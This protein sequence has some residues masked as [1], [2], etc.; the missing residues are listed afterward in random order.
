LPSNYH[1][2]P[3]LKQNFGKHRFKDDCKLETFMI[4]WLITQD[5]D[6]YQQGREELFPAYDKC[7]SSGRNCVQLGGIAVLLKVDLLCWI[8]KQGIHNK[9]LCK[10]VV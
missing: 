4:K 1:P 10:L 5:T 9:L 8:R 6:F 7:L 2:F 3:A